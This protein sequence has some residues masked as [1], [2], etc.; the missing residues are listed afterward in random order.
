MLPIT[1]FSQARVAPAPEDD[2]IVTDLEETCPKIDNLVLRS[3]PRTS[4]VSSKPASL[5]S[6]SPRS[7]PAA[8]PAKP[9]P[10]KS[11]RVK[12]PVV[13]KAESVVEKAESVCSTSSRTADRSFSLF[14]DRVP[15]PRRK[16]LGSRHHLDRTT[17]IS[18]D[19]LVVPV[20]VR[21]CYCWFQ[22][23]VSLSQISKLTT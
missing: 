10:A 18:K 6:S 5:K 1:T 17:K 20:V 3:S 2:L 12:S 19:R 22:S 23:V 8:V 7:P 16:N 21:L 9:L 13:E 15:T 11:V 14:G 4:P